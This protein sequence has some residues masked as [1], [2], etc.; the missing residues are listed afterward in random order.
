[1]E[2]EVHHKNSGFAVGLDLF[3]GARILLGRRFFFLSP[4][5]IHS[6]RCCGFQIKDFC[7]QFSK[8]SHHTDQKW[9]TGLLSP[10]PSM[11][12]IS[13]TKPGAM[14]TRLKQGEE[15]VSGPFLKGS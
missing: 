13:E 9:S 5:D 6:I 8:C 4:S 1:M 15:K 11:N 10:M 14:P 2:S 3:V 12:L 7:D